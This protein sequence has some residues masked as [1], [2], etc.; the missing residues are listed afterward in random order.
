MKNKILFRVDGGLEKGLGH[1]IRSIALAKNLT[2]SSNF[3]IIFASNYSEILENKIKEAGFSVFYNDN[4]KSE[5]KFLLEAIN[6]LKITNV[7][8][9]NLHQYSYKFIMK[10]KE[11]SDTKVIFLHNSCEGSK[12]ACATIIPSAHTDKN[13]LL[14]SGFDEKKL[15]IGPEY[16]IINNKIIDLKKQKKESNFN[17]VFRIVITT[18]GS[19]PKGVLL[20]LLRYVDET[21]NRDM[22]IIVLVGEGFMHKMELSKILNSIGKTSH[23]KLKTVPYSIK[24]LILADI[25]ISTFGVSTYELMYL[26]IPVLSVAHAIPNAKGSN[27]LANKYSA[28]KDLGLIDNLT[29]ED[30]AKELFHLMDSLEDREDLVKAG[31]RLIDGKGMDRVSQILVDKFY[32]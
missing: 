4:D 21:E 31:T 23:L 20:T 30:F 15:F 8:I 1:L 32:C 17:K 26:G 14:A 13:L 19:D 2:F 29:K 25:A 10:L 12:Q 18:G 24:E 3:K 5:E 9:D 27:R 6:T 28:I 11:D 7:F 22:E 16:V